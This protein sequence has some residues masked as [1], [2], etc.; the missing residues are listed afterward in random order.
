MYPNPNYRPFANAINYNDYNRLWQLGSR[1][2]GA[3]SNT[4]ATIKNTL[5]SEINRIVAGETRKLEDLS[6]NMGMGRGYC[7]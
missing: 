1:V 4:V 5:Q 2:T 6:S 7:N 3:D